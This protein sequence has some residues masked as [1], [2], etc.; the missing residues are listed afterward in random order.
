M[1]SFENTSVIYHE[2]CSD[3]K[4]DIVLS[5]NGVEFPY[6]DVPIYQGFLRFEGLDVSKLDEIHKEIQRRNNTRAPEML[7]AAHLLSEILSD[8]NIRGMAQSA[9]TFKNETDEIVKFLVQFNQGFNTF[10]SR[11]GI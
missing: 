9:Q 10:K 8:S 11:M 6:A 2:D 5:Q 1:I 7:E 4:A 3:T